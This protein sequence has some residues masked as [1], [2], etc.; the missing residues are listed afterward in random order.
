VSKAEGPA[1]EVTSAIP[2][3][4]LTTSDGDATLNSSA[5]QPVTPSEGFGAAAAMDLRSIGPYRLQD[6][7]GEGGMGQ[8][9]LAEQTAPIR[10]QVALK[11]IRAGMYDDSLLQR[12]FSE[13]QSLAIMDHPSIAKV[14]DAGA[15]Y[16]G[17]AWC[18]PLL[19]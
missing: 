1:K 8:V 15:T 19:T 12:F 17:S 7:L 18:F 16:G 3:R 14:F 4:S 5:A 13:R 11:L 6:K 9:W 2:E 10:R